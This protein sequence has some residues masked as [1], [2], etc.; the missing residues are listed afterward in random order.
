MTR[1]KTLLVL[2][3][4][5]T[6]AFGAGNLTRVMDTIYAASGEMWS[7]KVTISWDTFTTSDGRMVGKGSKVLD[8]V[9]GSLQVDLEATEGASPSGVAYSVRWA[10]S[11]YGALKGWTETWVVGL[12]ALPLAVKD[13]RRASTLVIFP[14]QLDGTGAVSGNGLCWDGAKYSP[15][16]CAGP[17]NSVAGRAG[18]VVLAQSDIAGLSA[19]LAGKLSAGSNLTDVPD[20]AVARGAL[21][22]GSAAVKSTGTGAGQI[23]MT[24]DYEPA[25][26]N[27][28]KKDASGNVVIG[29]TSAAA[30]TVVTM[31]APP[32]KYS[33]RMGPG[34]PLGQPPITP[35][36]ATNGPG[37][38]TGDYRYCYT[39]S[40]SSGET[41]CSP[42]SAAV[43]ASSNTVRVT[44][45]MPRASVGGQRLY[46]KLSTD[47]CYRFVRSY[48]GGYFQ[49]VYDD[50]TPDGSISGNACAPNVD[51]SA[52]YNLEV[53]DGVKTFRSN[54]DKG[55][56]PADV[57]LLTGDSGYS[58]KY[59]MDLYATLMV[60]TYLGNSIQSVKTG[61]QANHFQ[62][63]W[64][65]VVDD[66]TIPISVF[67]LQ[68]KG[69]VIIAP[70]GPLSDIGAGD[71]RA[72]SLSVT[73]TLASVTTALNAGVYAS[74]AGAGSGAFEQAATYMNLA[75]GYTGTANSYGG[76]F[77]NDTASGVA[78]GVRG[79]TAGAAGTSV[80]VWGNAGGAS[81]NIGAWASSTTVASGSLS[82]TTGA[83]S[84]QGVGGAALAASTGGNTEALV[85]LFNNLT[86]VYFV[87]HDGAV[88]SAISGGGSMQATWKTGTGGG[89]V[90]ISV[91]SGSSAKFGSTNGIPV[92]LEANGTNYVTIPVDGGLKVL[93]VAAPTCDST[94]RGTL[95]YLA[96]AGGVKDT[97][98]VCAKDASDAYAWRVVY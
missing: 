42:V 35:T 7:G 64:Q 2:L 72:R 50:N 31:V 87:S 63:Y 38:L 62:A 8:V 90:E 3:L 84:G 89:Q 45:G 79:K 34:T 24:G 58:Q 60:R 23:P 32:G 21:G 49:N 74:I 95:H 25:N 82:W 43:T 55:G 76:F 85:V 47:T 48:G 30:S 97:V 56:S 92:S 61:T 33:A 59:A 51:T 20:P 10:T 12:S 15:G 37:V 41:V 83:L 98:D 11:T 17:V 9:N 66:G 19:A 6:A 27:I 88:W 71:A 29:A 36:A 94:H 52:T 26:S 68:P 1:G 5:A 46:R 53:F 81:H 77:N 16:V 22:L 54:P 14:S 91:T 67:S 75:V 80:G 96:G 13:V 40:D 57:T 93:T 65:D 4:A 78:V 39:E 86:P 73:G 18:D 28:L 69:Q 44:I 70:T